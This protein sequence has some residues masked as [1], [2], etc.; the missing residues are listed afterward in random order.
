MKDGM[1]LFGK[2][3]P[4]TF[5]MLEQIGATPASLPIAMKDKQ[6]VLVRE[7]MA[8]GMKEKDSTTCN[9]EEQKNGQLRGISFVL[10]L[11]TQL[12]CIILMEGPLS[13]TL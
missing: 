3:P 5:V 7:C 13:D 11:F 8:V 12:G 6:R 1:P 9:R 2:P 4:A 10:Y